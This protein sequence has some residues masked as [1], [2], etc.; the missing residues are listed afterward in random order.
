[1]PDCL[2]N[3]SFNQASLINNYYDY[4]FLA[5]IPGG[6]S[7][8]PT[9]APSQAE[10]RAFYEY[11]SHQ[12]MTANGA[13]PAN[14]ARLND[15]SLN[16][17]LQRDQI[18]QRSMFYFFFFS[19]IIHFINFSPLLFKALELYPTSVGDSNIT[20]YDVQASS[21]TPLHTYAVSYT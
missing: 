6:F 16:N 20:P 2:L 1:M 18:L 17:Q 3:D 21:P 4:I 19:K 10:N 14:L 8:I 9:L 11:A 12:S 5:G 15:F 7:Y 13:N